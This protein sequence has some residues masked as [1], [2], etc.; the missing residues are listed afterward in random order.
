MCQIKTSIDDVEPTKIDVQ[1][2]YDIDLKPTEYLFNQGIESS[3]EC[4]MNEISDST[5][6][7]KCRF[8]SFAPLLPMC[9]TL[10]DLLCILD[11]AYTNNVYS[12]CNRKKRGLTFIGQMDRDTRF[13]KSNMT[14]V[15][16]GLWSMTK[17]IREEVDIITLPALIG[18]VGGSLGMFFGFSIST[19]ILFSLEKMDSTAKT[20]PIKMTIFFSLATEVHYLVLYEVSQSFIV[21]FSK[22]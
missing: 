7:S 16:M 13:K 2:S 9:K 4:W 14:R 8:T 18:S 22:N 1:A 10:E 20:T 17:E 12:R 19:L 21:Y 6:Q 5:C 11:F 15:G 3:E